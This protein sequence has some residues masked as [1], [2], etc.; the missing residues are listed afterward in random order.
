MKTRHD[1]VYFSFLK[2]AKEKT[3][4]RGREKQERKQSQM[5]YSC[6][7]HTFHLQKK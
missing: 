7:K 5:L 6:P 2:N 1:F 3:D 4:F